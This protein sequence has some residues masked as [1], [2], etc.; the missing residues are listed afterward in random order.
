MLV[1]VF[2]AH[3][4]LRIEKPRFS[5]LVVS[6]YK[7]VSEY[8]VLRRRIIKECFVMW[9]LWKQRPAFT[10][11]FE[12]SISV[13]WVVEFE[14]LP[15]YDPSHFGI[16]PKIIFYYPVAIEIIGMSVCGNITLLFRRD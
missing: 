4:S 6:F 8:D 13:H 9:E 10:T 5:K 14:P 2:T 16:S 11:L 3:W 1:D 12:A 15:R 7:T